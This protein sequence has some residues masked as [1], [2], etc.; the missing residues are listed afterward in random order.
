MP[1]RIRISIVHVVEI[2]AQIKLQKADFSV[3]LD[4]IILLSAK[5]MPTN[6]LWLCKDC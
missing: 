5:I 3:T 1:V 2:H 6:L 4:H